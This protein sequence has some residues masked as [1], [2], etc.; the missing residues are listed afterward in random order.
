MKGHKRNNSGFLQSFKIILPG[1]RDKTSS[2]LHKVLARVSYTL[3]LVPS[4]AEIYSIPRQLDSIHRRAAQES[5]HSK[6]C[7]FVTLIIA[8]KNIY[9]ILVLLKLLVF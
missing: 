8:F 6:H 4:S 7:I 2:K 9:I 3:L 1:L 5:T